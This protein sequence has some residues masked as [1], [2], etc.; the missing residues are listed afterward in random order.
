MWEPCIT[1]T[2]WAFSD[3][4]TSQDEIQCDCNTAILTLLLSRRPKLNRVLV[5]LS[6][7][8]LVCLSC[9]IVFLFNKP[10]TIFDRFHLLLAYERRFDLI[11]DGEVGQMLASLS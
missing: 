11:S 8:G 10:E 9:D 5:F 4:L 2:A 1:F 3:S 7:I 6:V